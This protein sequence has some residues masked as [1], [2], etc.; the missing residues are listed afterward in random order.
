MATHKSAEKRHRQSLKRNEQNR[1]NRQTIRSAMKKVQVLAE[2]G[3]TDG[4]KTAAKEAT[5][6]L[7]KAANKGLVKKN[8]A[9][10]T[11]SRLTVRA[12]KTKSA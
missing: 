8:T 7:A 11:I 4:A 6:L 9:S 12:A 10:R 1:Q 2:S 5:S 3:D